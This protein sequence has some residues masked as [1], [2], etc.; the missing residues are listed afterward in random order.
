MAID[1]PTADSSQATPPSLQKSEVKT[2]TDNLRQL[3]NSIDAEKSI[4]CS[5]LREHDEYVGR[6]LEEKLNEEYFYVPAHALLFKLILEF[7]ETNTAP[8]I[9]AFKTKLSDRG[10]LDNVGGVSGLSE[11]W[12]FSATS[13]HFDYHLNIVKEKFTLRSII[14]TSTAAIARAYEDQEEVPELLDEVEQAVLKIREGNENDKAITVKEAI[15]NVIENFE[16]M[17]TGG[18]QVQGIKTGY[19][20]LDNISG[21]LKKGEM[22]VIAA[23]PSMGKTSYMM[24]VVEHICVDQNI[25][26]LV[27]SLEMSTEQLVQ[28]LLFSRARFNYANILSKGF[29][30]NKMDFQRITRASR[31]ISD[32][33]LFI[34]DTPS[35]SINELRAKA[36]RKKKD[37]DIGVIAIDYLQL[38][39]SHTAQAK[40]S[41]E[42]EIAEISAG[43]KA[44]AKELEIPVIVLAQLN[45]GPENR[46]GTPRMSDLRESGSIEQDADMVGLL[47]RNAYY[48]DSE[49]AKEEAGNEAEVIIAKN[50]NG[51]TGH[52]P[53][54]FIP[55]LMRFE[56]RA[57]REEQN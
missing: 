22:F 55:E 54:T 9:I 45:R 32:A 18:Q 7:F 41:R 6:A 12:T 35:I 47:F 19:S 25:P 39:R 14:A 57:F 42:R 8:E 10:L 40:N 20:D 44:I 46:G 15:R 34:D 53:L 48:A 38:M 51:A 16:E 33:N 43:L 31:E 36:R 56:Q 37:A 2:P 49:E 17:I 21:G 1:S 26:G 3:P 30:P 13:A 5:M 24:N 50:R 28:R 29:K 4:L 23:R 52:L 27:F 11:I